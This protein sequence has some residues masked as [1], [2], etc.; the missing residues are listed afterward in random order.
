MAKSELKVES[1][2]VSYVA[3]ERVERRWDDIPPDERSRVSL[4]FTDR[5]MAVA[6]LYRQESETKTA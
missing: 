5:F 1:V 4:D 2:V 3:G 6:G